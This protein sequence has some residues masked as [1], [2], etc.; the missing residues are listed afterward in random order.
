LPENPVGTSKSMNAH[1]NYEKELANRSPEFPYVIHQNEYN[2]SNLNYSKTA[3]T[4]YAIDEIIS[5]DEDDSPVNNGDVVVGLENLKFGH[6]SDD[7]NV[8]YVRNDILEMDMVITRLPRSYEEEVL[9]LQDVRNVDD[10]D[11]DS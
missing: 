8:V 9:G 11:D 6:G 2:H 4:Y 10:D 5:D 3:F 7:A 1:W